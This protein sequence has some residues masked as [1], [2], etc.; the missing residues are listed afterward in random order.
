MTDALSAEG[1]KKLLDTVD[2][3]E[4]ERARLIIK[5]ALFTG[6]RKGEILSL[7]FDDID[8]ENGLVTF[9]GQRTKNGKTQTI[10]VNKNALGVL[11]RC[12]ELRVS[13]LVFPCDTGEFYHS[14]SRTWRRLRDAAGVNVRFHGLRHSYASFLA[15]SGK[16]DLYTIKELLGH[17]DL[18]MTA[19]Y[20][21]LVDASLRRAAGVLDGAFTT[22]DKEG[23]AN[24]S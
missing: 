1:A 15:S 8:Y 22:E 24:V 19:R 13:D 18:A 3:D 16:V 9:Q 23:G 20:S 7:T 5:F 6:R 10:P 4:N 11:L 2:A 17:K 12:R 21:H 14:F